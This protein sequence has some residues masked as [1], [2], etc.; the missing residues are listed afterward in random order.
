MLHNMKDDVNRLMD[1]NLKLLAT[2]KK[3]SYKLIEFSDTYGYPLPNDLPNLLDDAYNIMD[4][5]C[6]PTIV[7]KP[8]SMCG[9]LNP[10]DATFCAYCGTTIDAI[11]STSPMRHDDDKSPKSDGT[12]FIVRYL[13]MGIKRKVRMC[14]E[15]PAITIPSQIAELHSIHEEDF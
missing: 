2:L 9:K 10:E 11:I 1:L 13:T 7:I 4:E 12:H 14:G 5:L 6:H 3:I 8:C 15:S